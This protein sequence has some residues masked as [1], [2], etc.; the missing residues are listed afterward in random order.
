[1]EK[2]NAD[3]QPASL[4]KED[5]KDMKPE[6]LTSQELD[7]LTSYADGGYRIKMALGISER[8]LRELALDANIEQCRKCYW[9][10]EAGEMIPDGMEEPDGHCCNCRPVC[11]TTID[12][13][14]R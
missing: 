7:T 4:H 5:E 2:E 12:K 3:A 13:P 14:D 9:W 1:M 8:V 6:P 11:E 10:C